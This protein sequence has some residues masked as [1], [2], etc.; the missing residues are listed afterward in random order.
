VVGP[1]LAARLPSRGASRSKRGLRGKLMHVLYVIDSLASGGSERSLAELAPAL[2]QRGVKLDVGYLHEQPGLHHELI[3][4]GTA[5][6]PLDGAGGRLGQLRRIRRLVRERQ[7]D[8][9]HTTLFEADVLGRVAARLS[10]IPLV[11]SLVS[12]PYGPEQLLDPQLKPW[13]VRAAK[14]IDTAT[15]RLVTRFHAVTRHVADVMGGR[16]RIPRSRIDVIYRS[17]NPDTLGLR[18]EERRRA[19]RVGLGVSP[20]TPL[21]LAVGRHEFAKGLDVLLRAFPIVLRRLP[22]ARLVI[23]GREGNQTAFLRSLSERLT[24]MGSVHFLGPRDDVPELLCATDVVVVPSRWEGSPNVLIEA[25]ALETPIVASDIPAVREMMGPGGIA[26][27]S[28][29]GAREELGDNL[30]SRLEDQGGL[31]KTKEGRLLFLERF[32]VDRAADATLSFYHRALNSK[33]PTP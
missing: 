10:G 23:A 29:P 6:F 25:L 9:V 4:A 27:L 30:M 12:V 28:T 21:V 32:T 17:R 26:V 7:P 11:S 8:L 2:V 33:A 1:E 3:A 5:L 20:D 13:K 31:R 18:T 24:L 15:A 22:E 14:E 19:A 16:L